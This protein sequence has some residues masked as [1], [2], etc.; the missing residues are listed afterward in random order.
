MLE[1]MFLVLEMDV[2]GLA[3]FR[4]SVYRTSLHF[5]SFS[6]SLFPSPCFLFFHL[7]HHY[8]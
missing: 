5:F 4:F 8:T 2:E 3:T 6:F 7:S 1:V